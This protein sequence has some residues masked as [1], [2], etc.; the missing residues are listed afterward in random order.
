MITVT[1]YVS[2]HCYHCKEVEQF[3][4]ELS[5]EYPHRIAII[6][7][8]KDP[9]AKHHYEDKIPLVQVGPYQLK[10]YITKQDL[11]AA[12]G[13]ATDRWQYLQEKGDIPF[14]NR[15]ERGKK[16]NGADRFSLWLSSR[17]LLVFN[18]AIFL[19]VGLPFLA[20]M[21]MQAGFKTPAKVIYTVYKP[22]CHQLAFRSWYLFGEQPYYPRD[23]AGLDEITTYEQ[24]MGSNEIDIHEARRFMGNDE[25]GYKVALCQRD[26][27]IYLSILLF[28]L[29][30]AIDGRNLK[31]LPWYLWVIFGM[32]PIGVDGISQLP[33]II[34]SIL[35]SWIPVR[36]ST[37]LLRT[38]TGSLFGLTTAWYVYPLIEETMRET[39]RAVTR[40]VSIVNKNQKI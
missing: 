26:I 7:I 6:D 8:D 13:A 29:I 37:P 11:R 33:G 20:P 27:A 12:L 23:L 35:P 32:I 19:Y 18:I 39:K 28:G 36:E 15:Y 31:P 1:L 40:K 14:K 24:V 21:L 34:S 22:L 3:L 30:F 16:I 9:S 25:I 17:Y 38:I 5:E 10:S 2:N 4:N